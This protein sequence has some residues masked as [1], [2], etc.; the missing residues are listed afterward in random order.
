MLSKKFFWLPN[1]KYELIKYEVIICKTRKAKIAYY[2]QHFSERSKQ[3]VSR[4]GV[5]SH[6]VITF[7]FCNNSLSH[8]VIPDAL[9]NKLLSHSVIIL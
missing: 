4:K 5:T 3:V 6:F 8:F 1:I 2:R 9:C 7:A